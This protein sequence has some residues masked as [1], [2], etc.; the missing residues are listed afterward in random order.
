[1]AGSKGVCIILSCEVILPYWGDNTIFAMKA[2]YAYIPLGLILVG[3][4]VLYFTNIDKI[5]TTITSD[6][7][8][9][10]QETKK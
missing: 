3:I 5:Y 9:R 1:M 8:M 10:R 6:L 7:E 2:L 4:I